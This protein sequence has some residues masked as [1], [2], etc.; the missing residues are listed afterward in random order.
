MLDKNGN[1]QMVAFVGE[2]AKAI[3][4]AQSK[5]DVEALKKATIGKYDKFDGWNLETSSSTKTQYGGFRDEAGNRR[6]NPFDKVETEKPKIYTIKQTKDGV[7]FVEEGM[8]GESWNI[9][10]TV[11]PMHKK[12]DFVTDTNPKKGIEIGTNEKTVE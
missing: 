11:T 3:K 7:S 5:G 10:G 6:L 8:F 12:Y 1:K 2:D 9:N 4:A